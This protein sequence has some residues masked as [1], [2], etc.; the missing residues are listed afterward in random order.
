MTEELR[1]ASRAGQAIRPAN[2]FR[3]ALQEALHRRTFQNWR[4][5]EEA[6]EL[7]G[8]GGLGG[9]LRVAYAVGDISTIK[10]QLNNIVQRRHQIV[11]EGDLIRH[12][13]GGQTRVHSI[14]TK[15][16]H[17]SLDC[18]D[19]LVGHLNTIT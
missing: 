7:I 19:V 9:R 13:R 3:I 12:Q 14:T 16:V 1:K 8:I 2:Q 18:L 15:Y 6:F 5:V 11:H 10:N 17:D 4:E